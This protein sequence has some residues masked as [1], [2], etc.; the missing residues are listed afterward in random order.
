[1]PVFKAYH[2]YVLR[3]EK[4]K[5]SSHINEILPIADRDISVSVFQ[6]YEESRE[7]DQ[8]TSTKGR[9]YGKRD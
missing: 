7:N 9:I 1:M 6:E 8:T 4:A 5:K 2:H 3:K